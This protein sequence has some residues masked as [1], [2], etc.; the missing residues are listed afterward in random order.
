MRQIE[1]VPDSLL[2]DIAQ[3]EAA[4]DIRPAAYARLT[5]RVSHVLTD[6]PASDIDRLLA[7]NDYG[8]FAQRCSVE[9]RHATDHVQYTTPRHVLIELGRLAKHDYPLYTVTSTEDAESVIM[10]AG[11]YDLRHFTEQP[12]LGF[13]VNTD[14]EAPVLLPVLSGNQYKWGVRVNTGTDRYDVDYWDITMTGKPQE[15]A[16]FSHD[17]SFFEAVPIKDGKVAAP[18]LIV[19]IGIAA[20]GRNEVDYSF[21]PDEIEFLVSLGHNC[22]VQ[23]YRP[24]EANDEGY[25][26]RK[27]PDAHKKML[28]G[29]YKLLKPSQPFESFVAS[30]YA[31]DVR[32]IHRGGTPPILVKDAKEFARMA[33]IAYDL[34]GTQGADAHEIM[35]E[36]AYVPPKK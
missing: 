28:T 5:E 23:C 29:L 18:D 1:G 19:A 4:G 9:F 2:E 13:E 16:P 6:S 10:S 36:L 33:E 15:T 21:T 34:S 14:R 26:A 20:L 30:V 31:N 12:L 32:R 22:V 11:W 17:G 8:E 25:G 7:A 3:Y 27:D 24:V 35:R